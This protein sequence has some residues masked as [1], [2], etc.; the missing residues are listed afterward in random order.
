MTEQRFTFD[1]VAEA[2]DRSRPRY[3]EALIDAIFELSGIAA[4]GKILEIGC[5]TGQATRALARRGHR[6]LGLEPGAQMGALARTRLAEFPRVEIVQLTFEAWP[7]AKEIV[8]LVA[9]AQAFHWIDPTLRFVKAADALR[10]G[11]SL[12]VIGNAVV[13]QSIRAALDAV[14]ERHAPSLAHT[15]PME[16]YNEQGPLPRLFAESGRF[17]P[18][19]HRGEPWT[20]RYTTAQYLELLSTQSDHRLLPEAQREALWTAIGEAIELSGGAV[21]V[22]YEAHLHLARRLG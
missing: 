5:G 20:R 4:D 22:G 8:D 13:S 3:P 17:G 18:V 16:W 6:I 1:A 21:T 12:A 10:P 11:G 2:Y 15:A 7:L 9:S 19:A 14:Y